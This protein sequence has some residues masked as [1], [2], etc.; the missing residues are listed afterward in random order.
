MRNRKLLPVVNILIAIALLS[1]KEKSDVQVNLTHP[2]V[3]PSVYTVVRTNA[4]L[5]HDIPQSDAVVSKAVL[6][7]NQGDQIIVL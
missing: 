5:L 1:C 7:L 3:D 6:M 4:G 2:M